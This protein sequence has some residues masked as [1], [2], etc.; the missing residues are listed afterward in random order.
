[1]SLFI[2]RGV[3]NDSMLSFRLSSLKILLGLLEEYY[4]KGSITITAMRKK[5]IHYE[6]SDRINNVRHG[7]DYIW[8]HD[9]FK[10]N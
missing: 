10:C 6:I 8:E 5:H 2:K 1:V 3:L 7:P 4:E 9:I